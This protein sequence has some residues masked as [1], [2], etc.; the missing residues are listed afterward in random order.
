MREDR[1][2]EE[3]GQG[4]TRGVPP[5]EIAAGGYEPFSAWP[6]AREIPAD[7]APEEAASA[8]GLPRRRLPTDVAGPG[9]ASTAFSAWRGPAT[10]GTRTLRLCAAPVLSPSP[11]F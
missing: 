7:A 6:P 3:G 5:R 8:S 11:L 9:G 4:R 2:P 10:P 1:G